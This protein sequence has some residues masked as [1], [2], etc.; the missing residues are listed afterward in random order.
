M[1]YVLLSARWSEPG[2]GV[3]A[4]RKNRKFYPIDP[5]LF[6]IFHDFGR[7]PDMTFVKSQE[8]CK[9]PVL[10]SALV[11]VL[12]ASELRHDPA[13]HPLRYFLGKKEID[14]VGAEAVEVKYRTAVDLNEFFWVSK[15]LPPSMKFTVITRQTHSVSGRLRA[16]P[17]K[18]WLLER[19][20]PR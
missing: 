15:V 11:E 2:S 14:F 7:S 19:R 3:D 1:N 17:L 6:H 5:F 13:M 4:P 16:I 10:M 18:E 9:D 12:V 8:R 20:G